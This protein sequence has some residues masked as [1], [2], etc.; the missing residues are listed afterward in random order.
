MY[1]YLKM[2]GEGTGS[3]LVYVS[4]ELCTN[5]KFASGCPCFEDLNPL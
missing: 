3:Q 1:T 2:Q 4:L 5:W